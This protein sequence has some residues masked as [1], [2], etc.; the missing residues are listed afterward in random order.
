MTKD[1]SFIIKI[2]YNLDTIA[3]K[4]PNKEYD[5]K[6]DKYTIQNEEFPKNFY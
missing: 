6:H 5:N 2:F 4:S 3:Y 1:F